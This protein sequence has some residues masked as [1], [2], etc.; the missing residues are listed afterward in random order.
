[1]DD[2]G[3]NI[4]CFETLFKVLIFFKE[5]SIVNDDLG[6]GNAKF[7]DLIIDGLR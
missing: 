4:T 5:R 2:K 7:Q 3:R 1:M 6:I